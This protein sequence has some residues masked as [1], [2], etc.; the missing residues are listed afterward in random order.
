MHSI[1]KFDHKISLLFQIKTKNLNDTNTKS[2]QNLQFKSGST[3]DSTA[4]TSISNH[5]IPLLPIPLRTFLIR[6]LNII[7]AYRFF[8]LQFGSFN[9]T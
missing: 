8:S 4:M 3:F 9:I 5:N 2:C 1:L 7:D 6:R